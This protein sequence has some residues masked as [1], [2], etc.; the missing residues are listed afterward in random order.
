MSLRTASHYVLLIVCY[1]LFKSQAIAQTA[2]KED[3]SSH[4]I[5]KIDTD[6]SG[7]R[8]LDINPRFITLGDTVW[9][10]SGIC[11]VLKRTKYE[12]TQPSAGTSVLK[13]KETSFLQV[14]GNVQYSYLFNSFVDTPYSQRDFQQHTIQTSLTI[15][16]K[17]RYPLRVN[18][19]ARISNSPFFRNFFN[20]G[21]FFDRYAYTR[22]YKQQLLDRIAG[23]HFQRPDLQM[24]EEALRKLVDK[25][26]ELA[27]RLKDPDILQ[28]IVEDRENELRKESVSVDI[29]DRRTYGEFIDSKKQELD[30][31]EQRI[32]KLQRKTDSLKNSIVR[33]L[34]SISQK[35]NKA[36]SRQE[37][38]K[39]AASNGVEI[40]DEKKLDNFL[41]NIKSIGIGRSLINYSELTAWDVSLTGFNM[42]Y[43]PGLYAAVAVGRIDYG[44][45]NFFGRSSRQKGQQLFMGRIGVGDIERKAIIFSAFT[46][47][48]Y[49]YGSFLSDSVSDKINLVGYSIEGIWKK[50]QYTGLT[51]EVAKSTKPVS[52]S[53]R[54]NRGLSKLFDFSD[55]SN[56]GVS[57]KGQTIIRETD[58]RFSG[59][60]RKTAQDFQSFSLFAYNTDQTAWSIK[61]DQSILQDKINLIA[62]LRRNDFTNPFTEKT[63]KTSTLFKTFQV[64]IRFPRWPSLSVGYYPGSQL[65]VVD[66]EK[67]RENAYYILN[68]SLIYSYAAGNTRMIS[69]LIY[70]SYRS[71]GTDSGFISYTGINYMAS[72]TFL[73]SKMQIQ[74]AYT[75]TD[76]ERMQFYT[77]EGSIDYTITSRIR[78]GGGGK[79]NKVANGQSYWGSRVQMGIEFNNLG[80]F[81]LQYEKSYLPTI[82]QTLF[83]VEIGRIS[84]FKYF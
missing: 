69:S 18:L 78:I 30:S 24:A 41:S 40:K 46:G 83:A 26:N 82:Y 7:S 77:L 42:E 10:Y 48:K 19:S 68:G 53:F 57:V 4:V 38:K 29:P 11:K 34:S 21:L 28:R 5:R 27:K 56:I 44:F 33:D 61:A 36:S 15:T 3:P 31:L 55:R 81:Q 50:D 60:Y 37:M 8:I 62:M 9:L 13:K 32:N 70:N 2:G 67:I 84:W 74:S 75:Y 59:F 79:Y 63:F 54:S 47:T 72:Q 16:V 52:S 49:N 39:I 23:Y 64:N 17:D 1:L 14:H 12:P 6:L 51:A 66:K 43:N 25:Y 35:I 22:N 73:F 20:A 71:K 58:T 45:G 80:G 76:Q 65:Y